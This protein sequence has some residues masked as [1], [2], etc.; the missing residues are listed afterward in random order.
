MSTA[1]LTDADVWAHYEP[2]REE[3]AYRAFKVEQEAEKELQ[4]LLQVLDLDDE[5]QDR[6]FAALARRSDY[7]HP[8]LQPQGL[9]ATPVETMPLPGGAT[10]GDLVS[11]GPVPA[12]TAADPT[13]A[14][15]I[16]LVEAELTPEQADVY[17]RYTTERDAFWAGVVED[18][19]AELNAAP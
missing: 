6:V 11:A 9:A 3:L 7:F 16:D 1:M 12:P 10:G 5:Q 18:V 2:T 4:N 19:E 13:A 14:T 17:E 15:P 8:A